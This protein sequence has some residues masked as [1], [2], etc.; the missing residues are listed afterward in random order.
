M[1]NINLRPWREEQRAQEQQEFLVLT[2]LSALAGAVI[3]FALIGV[4]E[5]KLDNQSSRNGYLQAEIA[6]LDEKIKEVKE[7]N[8]QRQDLVERMELIQNLQGNRPVIVRVFDGITRS[9]PDDLFL[10][11]IKKTGKSMNIKGYS[12]ANSQIAELMR[13]F[14]AAEW[15]TKP[16]LIDVSA[17]KDPTNPY[18]AFSMSVQE[19]T[20]KSESDEEGES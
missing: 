19:V 6:K 12:E 8:K 17:S 7:L 15:F 1:P 10:N 13:N 4:M 9:V 14:D 3:S 18:S 2:G 20:P 5:G 16:S 11:E